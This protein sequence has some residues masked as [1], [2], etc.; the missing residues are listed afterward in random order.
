M[1]VSF[2]P[3]CRLP[4]KQINLV[5]QHCLAV[6]EKSDDD[7]E[8]DGG[9]RGSICDDEKCEDLSRH[10]TIQTGK[11][12]QVDVHGIENQLDRHE[13]D[14]DVA[15]RDDT[16][17]ADDEERETQKQVVFDRKHRCVTP[18]SWP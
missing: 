18:F 2:L 16:N 4:L 1:Q 17:H 9:F 5:S 12:H 8:A 7:S 15:A 3:P 11:G 14:N 13:H 6:T 10:I